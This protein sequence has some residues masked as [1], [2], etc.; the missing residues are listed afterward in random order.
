MSGPHPEVCVGGVVVHDGKLLLVRRG[1]GAGIGLWSVPGG[2]VDWGEP[3]TDALVREVA[4]ETGLAIVPAGWLGWVERIDVAHHF[5][6]HDFLAQL[7]DGSQPDQA[8]PGD[9]ASAVR[10]VELEE[11]DQIE[12]L[13]PGLLDFLRLHDVVSPA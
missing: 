11:L 8:R 4:E 7:A 9:D 10:W 1:R 12:D 2:R 6:I 13:V 5:V 3:L